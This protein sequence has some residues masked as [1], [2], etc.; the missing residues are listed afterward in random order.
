[1]LT[2]VPGL[3]MIVVH[4]YHLS[5]TLLFL[6]HLLCSHAAPPAAPRT[7]SVTF[8]IPRQQ[9]TITWNEPPLSMG[10]TVDMY[11]VN[12]SGPSALCAGI[13]RYSDGVNAPQ[14]LSSRSYTCSIQTPPQGG[15]TFTIKVA[16]ASCGSRLRGPESEPLRLQGTW[17]LIVGTN[18][19]KDWTVTISLV[20]RLF[21]AQVG[22]RLCHKG[23]VLNRHNWL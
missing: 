22:T 5:R 10:G 23:Y 6:I 17:C 8:L 7:P 18:M 21:L 13:D 4:A 19:T 16:G 9:F 12:I 1:M 20:P 11:F 2:K 15:D 3:I 14:V